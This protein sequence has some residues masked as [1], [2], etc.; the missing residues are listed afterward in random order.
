[1]VM[2][3][4]RLALLL[5]AALS[6]GMLVSCSKDEPQSAEAERQAQQVVD[7]RG[8][9]ILN[10]SFQL[11]MGQADSLLSEDD[12][13]A[14]PLVRQAKEKPHVDLTG[15]SS[16]RGHIFILRRAKGSTANGDAQYLTVLNDQTFD[17]HMEKG[18]GR[19][20][21]N[22]NLNNQ[23]IK[24]YV[25]DADS[26]KYDWYISVVL[27]GTKAGNNVVFNPIA[28]N[29][30]NT[31]LAANHASK[32]VVD[33]PYGFGWTKFSFT[34]LAA[35]NKTKV[36]PLGYFVRFNVENGLLNKVQQFAYMNRYRIYKIQVKSTDL[37]ANARFVPS[38]SGTD[39]ASGMVRWENNDP[40]ADNTVWATAESRTPL[41]IADKAKDVAGTPEYFW[42]WFASNNYDK[43]SDMTVRI[44]GEGTELWAGRK[45]DFPVRLTPMTGFREGSSP[46]RTLKLVSRSLGT[47]YDVHP[48]FWPAYGDVSTYLNSYSITTEMPTEKVSGLTDLNFSDF[49]TYPGG[50][51][52]PTATWLG[53][54]R[55]NK[56]VRPNSNRYLPTTMD[57]MTLF[58]YS[59]NDQ[60]LH[61]AQR[62]D[63]FAFTNANHNGNSRTMRAMRRTTSTT[64]TYGES[65]VYT[66]TEYYKSEGATLYAI[67]F[68]NASNGIGDKFRSAWRYTFDR[69]N[70][71]VR[72][73]IVQFGNHDDYYTNINPTSN[74]HLINNPTWWIQAERD[75]RVITHYYAFGGNPQIAE[76]VAYLTATD[77]SKNRPNFFMLDQYGFSSWPRDR[78]TLSIRDR[79]SYHGTRQTKVRY[80]KYNPLLD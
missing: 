13:R 38:L 43:T 15:V 37:F 54:Q 80:F 52:I 4:K 25:N 1:M 49:G 31:Y 28:G 77:Y 66:H 34:N 17:I 78:S 41:L 39:I 21:L 2:K 64:K 11:E 48:M 69:G 5:I 55:F 53:S 32:K 65:D 29:D 57:W 51:S 16:A 63:F 62:F 24:G 72:V 61:N 45:Y 30:P 50:N 8:D 70:K 44:E 3:C 67:R 19:I 12:L 76:S 9:R 73:D 56:S 22:L 68:V 20:Q 46:L 18:V 47:D 7:S 42:L 23:S 14:L 27:G 60:T 10:L 33:V 36:K 40:K 6:V 75:Q 35:L 74:V 59:H 26:E 79:H 71:Y 58:P